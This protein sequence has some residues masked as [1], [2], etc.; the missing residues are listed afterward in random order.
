MVASLLSPVRTGSSLVFALNPRAQARGYTLIVRRR[1]LGRA[2]VSNLSNLLVASHRL[3]TL[4]RNKRA[5]NL[6]QLKAL[7]KFRDAEIRTRDLFHPKEARYQAAPRPANALSMSVNK[8]LCQIAN[9]RLAPCTCHSILSQSI[10]DEGPRRLR[11]HRALP[12]GRVA[13]WRAGGRP[14]A[15][16]A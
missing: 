1:G 15:G 16:S 9:A 8:N 14:R 5:F 6:N 11:P 3:L 12:A 10:C 2:F 13:V 4:N 7:L